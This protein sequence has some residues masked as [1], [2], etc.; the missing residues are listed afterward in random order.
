MSGDSNKVNSLNNNLLTDLNKHELYSVLSP[1]TKK[2]LLNL[3]LLKQEIIASKQRGMKHTNSHS[4]ATSNV[5]S[6][7]SS[8]PP[9]KNSSENKRGLFPHQEHSL[10]NSRNVSNLKSNKYQTN[11]TNL[12]IKLPEYEINETFLDS[13]LDL[14]GKTINHNKN[15]IKYTKTKSQILNKLD[16]NQ[17]IIKNYASPKFSNTII[18]N[19]KSQFN[20][21]VCKSGKPTQKEN[22]IKNDKTYDNNLLE[23]NLENKLCDT[24]K[25]SKYQN[26][27]KKINNRSNIISPT[28]DSIF[29]F[30]ESIKDKPKRLLKQV[31]LKNSFGHLKHK[32]L[33]KSILKNNESYIYNPKNCLDSNKN[34]SY[35]NS[36]ENLLYEQN[37]TD[38]S[39]NDYRHIMTT[40]DIE[41][42]NENSFS[43]FFKEVE[44]KSTNNKSE[45]KLLKLEDVPDE[46]FFMDNRYKELKNE[47][48]KLKRENIKYMENEKNLF[49]TL[50]IMK[51][52]IKSQEV[53]QFLI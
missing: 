19:L 26:I 48:N 52:F 24:L 12:D 5:H 27:N 49:T 17:S 50:D 35:L 28:S 30:D 31:S 45:P 21:I 46:E 47:V 25:K 23:N 38:S 6:N 39:V 16:L 44:K 3:N 18:D 13:E 40:P 34:P 1:K 36:V 2:E 37:L 7:S 33:D 9:E 11:F 53:I 15:E 4:N 10:K 32:K 41:M 14:L 8:N 20:D 29:V 22:K 43:E 51:N 42:K